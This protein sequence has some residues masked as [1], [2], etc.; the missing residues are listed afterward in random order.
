MSHEDGNGYTWGRRLFVGAVS[1]VW[2]CGVSLCVC[3]MMADNSDVALFA[4]L[5]V[6][7]LGIAPT[8]ALLSLAAFPFPYSFLG[9]RVRTSRPN[10]KPD[11][12]LRRSW[13][14]VG[15]LNIS[16]P[17]VT[18]HIYATGILVSVPIIGDIFV[19]KEA[20]VSVEYNRRGHCVLRHTWGEVRSPIQGPRKIG[21]AIS[22]TW[23]WRSDGT[24]VWPA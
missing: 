17:L 2:A 5:C 8:S 7:P 9:S 20:I 3:A 6:A 18:W 23:N 14:V 11:A 12:W 19:P 21:E 1:V 10:V 15:F 22:R 24:G 4:L 13:A 16:W